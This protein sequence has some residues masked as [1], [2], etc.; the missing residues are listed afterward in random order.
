MQAIYVARPARQT[1]VE[2]ELDTMAVDTALNALASK[3]NELH[4][5]IDMVAVDLRDVQH[6]GLSDVVRRA[7]EAGAALARLEWALERFSENSAPDS[8][9]RMDRLEYSRD[10][11]ESPGGLLS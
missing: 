2:Q 10:G 7:E 3:V 9:A 6:D 4:R 5:Q 1:G 11:R 8:R